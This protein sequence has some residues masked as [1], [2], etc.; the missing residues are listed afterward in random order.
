MITR[1]FVYWLAI[2][3]LKTGAVA[4]PESREYSTLHWAQTR[5]EAV[6]SGWTACMM[7]VTAPTI[8]QVDAVK[9]ELIDA[10]QW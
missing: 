4:K 2:P 5:C 6:Y 9:Q 1:Y 3:E 10:G 8:E 7:Q